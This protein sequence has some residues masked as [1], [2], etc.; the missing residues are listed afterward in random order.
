MSDFKCSGCNKGYEID[1]LELWQVYDGEGAQTDFTCT[2][3]QTEF[4]ITTEI[5][6][7][8]FTTETID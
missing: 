3:C 6:E 8:K 7:W 4:T 1:K 5:V 2:E